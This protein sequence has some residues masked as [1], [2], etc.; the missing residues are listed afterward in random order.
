LSD[1]EIAIFWRVCRGQRAQ[2]PDHTIK[3]R[4]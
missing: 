1:D 2:D 3:P 4:H